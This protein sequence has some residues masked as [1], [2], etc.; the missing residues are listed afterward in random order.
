MGTGSSPERGEV[1]AATT[2]G[3]ARQSVIAVLAR[4]LTLELALVAL[5]V[6]AAYRALHL[7]NADALLPTLMSTQDLTWFYWGQDR[8]ANLLPLLAK[9]VP[10][11]RWNLSLQLGLTGVGWFGLVAMVA[12]NHARESTPRPPPRVVALATVLTGALTIWVLPERTL[13]LFVFEQLYAFALL[14]DVLGL[15]AITRRRW[16]W[17]VL[18]AALMLSATMVNPSLLLY[19]PLVFALPGVRWRSVDAAVAVAWALAAFGLTGF[20]SARWGDDTSTGDGYNEF[21][22]GRSWNRFDD[23]VANIWHSVHGWRSAVV[24]TLAVVVLAIRSD[25]VARRLSTTYL[26][27]ALFAFGWVVIFSGNAWVVSNGLQ[28]RYFFPVFAAAVVVLGGA[29]TELTALV[30]THVPASL[31]AQPRWLVGAAATMALTAPVVGLWTLTR[32]DIEVLSSAEPEVAAIRSYD[33]DIVTGDYW[34]AWP[35]VIAARDQGLDVTGVAYRWSPLVA[36]TTNMV[37]DRLDT[38]GAV[39]VLCVGLD[40][41]ACGGSMY[42]WG[43]TLDAVL[44]HDPLVVSVT[45]ER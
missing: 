26:G 23:A 41:A 2:E 32:V 22:P 35:I 18:G 3:S 15:L 14:V 10:D 36:E 5:V 17:R 25:R 1:D 39:T 19:V 44:S 42:Y 31:P 21:S 33:A 11:I 38:D 40:E 8:L 4:W 30:L 37:Y 34:R 29:A 24:I 27:A 28:E 9:P 20:A 16:S 45:L 6:A 43:L 7:A 12:V 13:Q